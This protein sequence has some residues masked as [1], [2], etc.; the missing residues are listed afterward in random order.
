MLNGKE[1]A[2]ARLTIDLLLV[3]A[4]FVIFG[5]VAA[6]RTILLNR[7]EEAAP[8]RNYF[9]TEYDRDLRQQSSWCDEENWLA[10]RHSRF[11]PIRL[12]DLGADEK[13]IRVM[14]RT[15]RDGESN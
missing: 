7:R 10:D 9:S 2:M 15:E 3:S 11:A 12:R 14:S 6:I 5:I 13:R 8:F 1:N 4:V